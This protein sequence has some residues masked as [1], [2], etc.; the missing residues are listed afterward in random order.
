[1]ENIRFI[2]VLLGTEAEEH[3]RRAIG[4][5]DRSGDREAEARALDDLAAAKEKAG[6]LRA[7]K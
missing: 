5:L 1:M 4:T 2:P 3:S 6:A 7:R